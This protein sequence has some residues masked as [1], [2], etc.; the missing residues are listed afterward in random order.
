V[1][2]LAV[3]RDLDDVLAASAPEETLLL[4]APVNDAAASGGK[5][6]ASPTELDVV[7][8]VPGRKPAP[9]ANPQRRCRGRVRSSTVAP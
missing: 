4:V 8:R 6:R 2:R 5:L 1:D 3:H 7:R 9:I